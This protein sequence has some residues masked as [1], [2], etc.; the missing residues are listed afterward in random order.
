MLKD[1]PQI[2]KS[3]EAQPS[4]ERGRLLD[5]KPLLLPFISYKSFLFMEAPH[6]SPSAP[7]N[8]SV[9]W[10]GPRP[11]ISSHSPLCYPP[12]RVPEPE[13]P[14][15]APSP[16]SAG[17]G[18]G[19]TSLSGGWVSGT[20]VSWRSPGGTWTLSLWMMS[21][22]SQKP[23][24]PSYMGSPRLGWEMCRKQGLKTAWKDRPGQGA[25]K[26]RQF[27]AG[28]RR[29]VRRQRT[30]KASREE[31]KAGGGPRLPGRGKGKDQ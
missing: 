31:I 26:N 21:S 24:G 3:I 27:R 15:T 14:P 18:P 13:H 12:G 4:L 23:S 1:L 22:S 6:I 19:H 2:T 5:F 30:G 25:R 10:A 17:A 29:E 7:V 9:P 11:P 20:W 16:A 8:V 28:P